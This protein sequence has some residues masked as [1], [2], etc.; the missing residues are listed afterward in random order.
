MTIESPNP[1]YVEALSAVAFHRAVVRE[2][3]EFGYEVPHPHS[4]LT[5]FVQFDGDE[6]SVVLERTDDTVVYQDTVDL[7]GEPEAELETALVRVLR[8]WREL[9]LEVAGQG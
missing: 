9:G 5:V 6:A 4:E 2:D 3:G 1:E 8:D 7:S